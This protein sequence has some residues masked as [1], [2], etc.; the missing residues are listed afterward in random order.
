MRKVPVI[1]QAGFAGWLP[2]P[3]EL[4]AYRANVGAWE[5]FWNR[6]WIYLLERPQPRPIAFDN[7]ATGRLAVMRFSP[8]IYFML[9]RGGVIRHL[10][11]ADHYGPQRL[12]VLEGS[13]ELLPSMTDKEALD[14]LWWKDGHPGVNHFETIDPA[15]VPTDRSNRADWW[16]DDNGKIRERAA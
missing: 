4:A 14:F 2:D 13:G 1:G 15:D 3:D 11:V 8:V 5:E 10:R 12:V 16:L 9:R 7:P 6:A